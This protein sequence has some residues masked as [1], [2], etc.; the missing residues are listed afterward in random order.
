MYAMYMYKHLFLNLDFADVE[1]RC[2][3]VDVPSPCQGDVEIEPDK[4]EATAITLGVS[5]VIKL[6]LTVHKMY[7]LKRKSALKVID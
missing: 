4:P 6:N 3:R 2:C 1:K 5:I 7:E